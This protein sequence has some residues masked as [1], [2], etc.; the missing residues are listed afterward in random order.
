MLITK[1]P[2]HLWAISIFLIFMY[3]MGIYDFFM[4]LSHNSI[5]YASKGF[6]EAV[7]SYFTNYPFY[8]MVFWIANLICGFVAPV[9]LPMKKKQATIIAL[10]SVI[11]DIILMVSTVLFRNRIEVLGINIFIFDIFILIITLGLYL[12]C[13]LVAFRS[14]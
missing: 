1:R 13:K 7:V 12:Y 4:M 5:Y 3:S 2:W 11:A 6:G 9:L 10:I 14:Q 8:I